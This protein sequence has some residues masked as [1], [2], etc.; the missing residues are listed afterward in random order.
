[1]ALLIP[2][3]PICIAPPREGLARL[4]FIERARLR[5]R[6]Q[7]RNDRV[8]PTM[9]LGHP[10]GN[11]MCSLSTPPEARRFALSGTEGAG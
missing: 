2:N 1:M 3:D 5:T 6:S 8:L 4:A 7:Y 9:G 11:C 10:R